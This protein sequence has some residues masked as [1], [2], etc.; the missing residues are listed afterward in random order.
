[1][2]YCNCRLPRPSHNYET[3]ALR[4]NTPHN[5]MKKTIIGVFA[6]REDAEKAINYIHNKFSIPNDD[7]SYIYRNTR[8]EIRQVDAGSISTKTPAEGA[9]RGAGAG[10]VVGALAGIAATIGVIPAIGPFFAAG[11]LLASIGVTG[12]VGA[13]AAGAVGGAVVGGLIGALANLG[14]GKEKAKRYEDYVVAGNILVAVNTEESAP[15]ES[16]LVGHN[17]VDVETYAVTV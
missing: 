17:A 14:I 9:S 15:V 4:A 16:A 10:A 11:P 5:I 3:V 13:T 7:I 6:N 8:N 2:S 12:A 1:M